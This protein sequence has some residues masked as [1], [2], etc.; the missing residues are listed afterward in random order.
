MTHADGTIYRRQA[1]IALVVTAAFTLLIAIANVLALRSGGDETS[2]QM[3][4]SGLIL[5][6]LA[7]PVFSIFLPLWL[8]H[9][10][11]LAYR[12]WPARG[13]W[14][15]AVALIAAYVFMLNFDAI[16][17]LA[18]DPGFDPARFAIHFV[19]A[20]LFHVP[21][22]L[23]FAILLLRTTERWLGLWPAIAITAAAFSLY[24]LGQFYFF[25]AGTDPLWLILLFIVFAA[26][27]L[28]YLVTRSLMLVAIGHCVSGAVNMARAGTYF[29][30]I[31]FVFFATIAL[32]GFIFLWS[33]FETARHSAPA[34][35]G[36]SW[37]R[38]APED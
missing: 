3:M 34:G 13:Q 12:W 11:K 14:A 27:L 22:Y 8:A 30:G 35:R 23:L 24:H 18:Q 1:L 6:L 37:L 10:W 33:V 31:G 36:Q 32:L 38:L 15:G 19:S 21:Y 25:P 9:R 20:M 5:A 4:A 28:I 17:A 16:S 7:L 2:V 26:D 29:D